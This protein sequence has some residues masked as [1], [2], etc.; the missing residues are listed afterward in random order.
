M[1]RARI[2]MKKNPTFPA[3]KFDAS[4]DPKQIEERKPNLSMATLKEEE[5]N[6]KEEEEKKFP[7]SNI[8]P[9]ILLKKQQLF[10]SHLH[11]PIQGPFCNGQAPGKPPLPS[12]VLFPT[13]FQK[14]PVIPEEKE[15]TAVLSKK[16][17]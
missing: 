14:L 17:Q 6:D 8:S 7:I 13:T 15:E 5:D 11:P 12:S 3:S 4:L 2:I 16:I 1:D 9:L 10:P